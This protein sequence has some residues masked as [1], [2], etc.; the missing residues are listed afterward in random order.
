MSWF[1]LGISSQC[2]L[3]V[4][5][6]WLDPRF[7]LAG[8]DGTISSLVEFR[9][10]LY[11]VGNFTRISGVNA[12]GLARW[13][14][15]KW[16]PVEPGYNTSVAACVS[17][18]EVLYFALACCQVN[19]PAGLMSWDGRN[20]KLLGT[21]SGYRDLIGQAL[22]INNTDVY[23]EA[24]PDPEQ[25]GQGAMKVMT[26]WDGMKW[27]V[28][29]GTAPMSGW[30]VGA[31]AYAGGNLYASGALGDLNLGLLRASGWDRVG[32]GVG[33]GLTVY[34]IASDGT[35]LFVEG[36]FSQAGSR[37][38][39][40]FAVWNGSQWLIPFASM[41]NG[42]QV[43]ALTS[44]R[45]AVLASEVQFTNNGF[46]RQVISQHVTQY[47]GTNR[48]VIARGDTLGMK[49][50]HKA[51]NGVYCAGD[52]RAVAG[53]TT[54]NLAFWDGTNWAGVGEGSFQGLS[55]KATCL[56][57]S[58]TN[59]YAGG[60]FEYAG[61][62]AARHIA[63]W[64]GSQW[65][66]LGSG[67]DGTVRQMA[68]HR[69]QLF[70]VGT[71]TSAGDTAATNIAQWN[72]VQWSVVGHQ[73]TGDLT[74]IASNGSDVLVART[75]NQTNFVISRWDGTNWSDFAGGSFG[76]G[77]IN[78]ILRKDD[79]LLIAGMFDQINNIRVNNIA[80]WNGGEWQSLGGGLTGKPQPVPN[81]YFFN[82]VTAAL[83]QDGNLYVGGSFTNAGGVSAKNIARWD[84]AQWW[85]LGDGIPG[86]GG[87][88]FGDVAHPVTSLAYVNGKLFAGGGFDRGFGDLSRRLVVWD[89][90]N[91]RNALDGQWSIDNSPFPS[92]YYARE[93]HVWA[94]ASHG[95]E[96]YIAGNFARIGTTPSY[97]FA[98][99]HES[100]PPVI[101]ASFRNGQVILTWPRDFQHAVLESTESLSDS[102][103]VPTADV[104]WETDETATHDV[105]VQL[106]ASRTQAF[107][108]LRWR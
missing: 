83:L 92:D 28:L 69:E 37:S 107:Y 59:V 63:R 20:W 35:N 84:G 14:G 85:A 78:I 76:Y 53:I 46:G 54:G 97:G 6:G 67:I 15:S 47:L 96:L 31:L 94:L 8:A 93:L 44:N 86:F 80:R 29:A 18:D 33:I 49:L 62:V 58:G 3:N 17:S 50:M 19:G 42:A 89:G 32:G 70:V 11:A 100:Q 73:L 41:R 25:L 108:R 103:W 39:D 2:L 4:Q 65:H 60:S 98:I 40:G 102:F 79:S 12:R 57:A 61:D 48:T 105:E 51:W 26:K 71:F 104:T 87:A 10:A 16:E 24:F 56:V 81:D 7:D 23:C 55:A 21:P 72:G 45:G 9:G 13:D 66:P 74:A 43:V 88:S 75:V 1:L 68:A 95:S 101:N 36:S 106:P 22:L 5:G 77:Q 52:F 38:A 91:W 34:G 82:E 99:W 27:S 64:D 30:G 90:L